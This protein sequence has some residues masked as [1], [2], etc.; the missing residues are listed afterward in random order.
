[1]VT[2]R[3]PSHR[4]K[5]CHNPLRLGILKVGTLYNQDMLTFEIL[6]LIEK[7]LMIQRNLSILGGEPLCPEK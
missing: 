2:R 4:C 1:M 5:G 7:S 6:K 3:L